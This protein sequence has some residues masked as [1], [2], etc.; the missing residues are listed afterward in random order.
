MLVL[1]ALFHYLYMQRL[2]KLFSLL[3][4]IAGLSVI[5]ISIITNNDDNHIKHTGNK[6]VA[7]VID[8]T[9]TQSK[10]I[11]RSTNSFKDKSVWGIYQFKAT[12]GK[13]YVVRATTSGAHIGGTTSIY[14]NPKNPEQEFY[15]ESD[16]YGVYLGA[17]IGIVLL[18]FGFIIFRR[19][20]RRSNREQDLS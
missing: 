1:K 11:H 13:V 16:A 10:S 3:A 7:T 12:D 9:V 17:G 5:V 20:A 19:A 15:L 14:Y 4:M 6:A 2:D 18:V 8:T